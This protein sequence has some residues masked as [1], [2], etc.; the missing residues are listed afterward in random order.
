MHMFLSQIKAENLLEYSYLLGV[1]I[2][3]RLV[4]I[5]REE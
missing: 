2:E 5:F 3:L 4:T 1:P